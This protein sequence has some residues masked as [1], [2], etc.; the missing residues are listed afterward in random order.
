MAAARAGLLSVLPTRY[1]YVYRRDQSTYRYGS[2]SAGPLNE[3]YLLS[4]ALKIAYA[5]TNALD[6][7]RGVSAKKNE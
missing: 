5:M 2:N 1:T 3:E 4:R 6:M 7:C